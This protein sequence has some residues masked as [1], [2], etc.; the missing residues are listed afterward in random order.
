MDADEDLL[1][2]LVGMLAAHDAGRCVV[3]VID[4][5]DAE[6]DVAELFERNKLSALISM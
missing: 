1:K 4:T 2:R 3:H 5:L 6:R